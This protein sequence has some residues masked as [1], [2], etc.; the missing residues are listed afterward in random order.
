MEIALELPS[1]DRE[2][3]LQDFEDSWEHLHNTSSALP[4]LLGYEEDEV[5][6]RQAI[7][8]AFDK[9][10]ATIA[11]DAEKGNKLE[12]R[13]ALVNGGYQ[14]RAKTLRQKTTEAS[15]ALEDEQIKED[16]LRTLQIAEKQPCLGGR[17]KYRKSWR[18]ST[19]GEEKLRIY[20]D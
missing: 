14:Q 8:E 3:R 2:K 1:G 19:G 6:E 20:T 4:G 18:L 11:E 16:S 9:V 17:S 7:I 13:L 10:Q 12:K 15:A 5:D